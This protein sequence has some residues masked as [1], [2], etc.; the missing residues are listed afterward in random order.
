MIPGSILFCT[1]LVGIACC[2][3]PA[4]AALLLYKKRGG[5]AAAFFWGCAMYLVFNT[6]LSYPVNSIIAMT[7][8]AE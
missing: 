3:V 5:R 8:L 7:P 4:L 1:G 6:V 2:A